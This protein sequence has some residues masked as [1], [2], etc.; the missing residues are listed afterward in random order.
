MNS[1]HFLV[2]IK[3]LFGKVNLL[4]EIAVYIHIPFCSNK[5]YYCDFVS[6]PRLDKRIDEYVDCLIKE[7]E[8]YKDTLKEYTVETVFIGGGTPSYIDEK[9]ILRILDYLY[10]NYRS[11]EIREITIEVNPETVDYE[12]VKAYR[13]IGINRISIGLQSTNDNLLMQVGRKHTFSDF[14]RSYEIIEKAGYKNISV[15]L[16]FGLPNQSIDD[17]INSL[18]N[19][20][21]LNVNHISYY[22]LIIEENTIMNKWYK[23]GR[24]KLPDENT[25]REMYHIGVELLKS[26]GYK[27]YEISNFA[28]HGYECKHNLFYWKIKP[29]VGFGISSHSNIGNRRFWNHSK[30]SNYIDTINDG[31]IPVEG[32]EYIDNDM[33]M[34]EF[35]IMGLR[36]IDGVNKDEFKKRFNVDIEEKYGRALNKHFT[37]GLI[38]EENGNIKF[39]KKGLDLSNIVYVDLL[40]D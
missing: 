6:F 17:C 28:K 21:D 32:E 13:D 30:Y 40:P 18:E 22:S 9:Y 24:I 33:Q 23:E 20:I 2:C 12:K 26:K 27:H 11:D 39:T 14:L 31:G 15:D 10:H 1:A 38:T 4:K 25:E 29:Y 3:H 5:C 16:M 7:M 36:L 8:M 34:A 35:M 37:Q 19:V